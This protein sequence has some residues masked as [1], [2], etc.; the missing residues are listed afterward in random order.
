MTRLLGL[1]LLDVEPIPRTNADQV[2]QLSAGLENETP[3]HAA[4]LLYKARALRALGLDEVA[5][6]TLTQ[7]YRRKKDRPEALLRQIRY[8]RALAYAVVGRNSDSRRELSAIY[9]EEPGFDD[10]AERLGCGEGPAR[11]NDPDQHIRLAAFQHCAQ[12]RKAHAGAV[13]WTA[14]QLGFR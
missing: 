4:L 12:L 14:I 2:V 3:V 9:A 10:V 6:S 13:P 11:M 7:A 5:V 1:G 8:E